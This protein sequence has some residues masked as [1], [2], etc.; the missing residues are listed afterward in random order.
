MKTLSQQHSEASELALKYESCLFSS[1]PGCLW[2]RV[3]VWPAS[4]NWKSCL[5]CCLCLCLSQNSWSLGWG[6]EIYESSFNQAFIDD[7]PCA[8]W[9]ID[10]AR[11]TSR[12]GI[13]EI[14]A[15]S[16]ILS[17]LIFSPPML[18]VLLVLYSI[19]SVFAPA[20]LPSPCLPLSYP[21]PPCLRCASWRMVARG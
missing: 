4:R 18:C 1:S 13:I 14:A 12:T 6:W 9:V 19:P 10:K 11:V 7:L 5:S 3:S 21:V 16:S 20:P 2:A 17:F 8:P 15:F